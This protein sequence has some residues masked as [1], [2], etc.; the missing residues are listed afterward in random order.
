MSAILGRCHQITGLMVPKCKGNTDSSLL[1]HLSVR[2]TF[3]REELPAKKTKSEHFSDLRQTAKWWPLCFSVLWHSRFQTRKQ[4]H[5]TR[6]DEE[7]WESKQ[8]NKCLLET[9]RRLLPK[10]LLL[11]CSSSGM[12]RCC[13]PVLSQH[14]FL[15]H[16]C[17]AG[18]L[19]AQLL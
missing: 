14:L 2:G 12:P 3:I 17:P 19:H 15:Q 18:F 10:L 5:G 7:S 1:V 16:L 4:K 9:P 13:I 8:K 6:T 11:C